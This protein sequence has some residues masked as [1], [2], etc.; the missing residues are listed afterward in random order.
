MGCL[1]AAAASAAC[2]VDAA[3]SPRDLLETID[4]S[5]LALSPDGQSLAFREDQ[6]DLALNRRQL[7]WWSVRL[8]A[9]APPQ[10][11]ADGGEALWSDAG[12]V[13][14][15]AP[16]WSAD[17][18]WIYYRALIDHQVQVWRAAADGARQEAVT[19][20]DADV[21]AFA[22]EPDRDH[23][24]YRTRAS[25]EAL[26]RAEAQEYDQGVRIDRTIDPAQNLFGAIAVDGRLASQRLAGVWFARTGLLADTPARFQVLDL[27][28]LSTGEASADAVKTLGDRVGPG[29]LFAG[30]APRATSPDGHGE[31]RATRTA[32]VSSVHVDRPGSTGAAVACTDRVCVGGDVV[33]LAWR[34]GHD[35]V[36]LTLSDAARRQSLY[37]WT[38]GTGSV[39]QVASG[40]GLLYGGGPSNSPCA[41][42]AAQAVCVAASAGEA[43]RL[44][45]IDLESGAT[46]D[47]AIPNG[48][49]DA[50]GAGTVSEIEWTAPDGQGFTGQL[51]LPPATTPTRR[52]PLFITYYACEGF[53]RGGVGDEW[54]LPSFAADGIAALC[55]NKPPGRGGDQD[56]VADYNTALT[57][58]RGA[59]A[60]LDA[61]GLIDPKHVGMGGLSFGSEAAMWVAMKSDLLTAV[62]IATPQLEPAY[63]W[64]N[65]APGRDVRINLRKVW[66]L[67]APDETR[68]RWARVS[69]AL[70]TA[71]IH[72]AILMQ[73]PEQEYRM[74][75][76]LFARLSASSTPV[77]LYAF[78]SEPH[79]KTQPRHKL[80]I[81][82][83]NLDWFRFWLLNAVD[84]DPAKAAQYARWR[85]MAAARAGDDPV[86]KAAVPP[87][88]FVQP[89]PPWAG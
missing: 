47:L 81:Y 48:A 53:V 29:P 6:A 43:P 28:D 74:G 16:Q 19:H 25:R 30:P 10:R 87:P 38:V 57:G 85:A 52:V 5:S 71:Q 36:A 72:A 61:Q 27:T 11:I 76:E 15:E 1:I 88:P 82:E 56:A 33:A 31:V 73:M 58:V 51:F 9:S 89:T 49:L 60:L 54:P 34:P 62:S 26:A 22:L 55:I 63:Y 86:P 69:P 4:I 8:D 17:G 23:L 67:G 20:D 45:A 2:A 75:L 50:A 44:R 64:T 37:L 3:P 46:H 59:I 70:N 40:A 18:R 78:A 14:D 65:G 21:E 77:E 80:A 12:V 32:G 66:G 41:A 79:L 68:G 83:R 84:P 24:T 39:R 35:Q 7:S 42:G 13:V